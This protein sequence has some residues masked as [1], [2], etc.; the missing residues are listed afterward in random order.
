[1]LAA[2]RSESVTSPVCRKGAGVGF[3]VYAITGGSRR[4]GGGEFVD[5][6]DG[7]RNQPFIRAN[8]AFSLMLARTNP[9]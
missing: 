3:K 7:Q 2:C 6:L 1:M 4:D 8:I 9:P 5:L